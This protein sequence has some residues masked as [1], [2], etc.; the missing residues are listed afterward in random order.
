MADLS[1]MEISSRTA[2]SRESWTIIVKVLSS[3]GI[4]LFLPTLFQGGKS[5]YIGPS[6]RWR[7][8]SPGTVVSIRDAFFSVCVSFG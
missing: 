8:E 4:F 2:R 1:C 7:R 5:L 6:I 3:P